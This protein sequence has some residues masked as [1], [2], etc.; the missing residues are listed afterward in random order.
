[1]AA[2]G[3]KPTATPK[4]S[5]LTARQQRFVEEYCVDFNGTQAAIRAGYSDKGAEVQ[6]AKLLRI[7]K[8]QVEV[9]KRK[10]NLA[11]KTD[12]TREFL[13]AETIKVLND[14]VTEKSYPTRVRAIELLAKMHGHI[15]EQRNVRMIKSITD[16]SEAEL[17]ALAGSSPEQPSKN[18]RH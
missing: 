5:I 2:N 8:V 15:V 14:C 18:T 6:A 16:L 3:R 9:A 1:M 11:E 4:P 7:P 12:I 17:A 10:S 13:V